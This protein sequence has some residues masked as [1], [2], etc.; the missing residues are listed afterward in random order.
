M[1][2]PAAELAEC[3]ASS[4]ENA[5]G[6][7]GLGATTGGGVGPLLPSDLT[8]AIGSGVARYN[9]SNC[10]WIAL[11]GAAAGDRKS[12][13][14][15]TSVSVRVDHGGRRIIQK[16]KSQPDEKQANEKKH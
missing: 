10:R 1:P 4:G 13:V 6:F 12:V 3:I 7:N 2:A 5:R 8:S 9:W 11:C 14:S 15:G 16:T